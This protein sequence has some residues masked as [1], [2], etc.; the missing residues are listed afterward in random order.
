MIGKLKGVNGSVSRELYRGPDVDVWA[1]VEGALET[2]RKALGVLGGL[3]RRN[4][5][6]PRSRAKVLE[7]FPEGPPDV[8]PP[9]PSADPGASAESLDESPTELP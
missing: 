6:T 4:S 5:F 1:A 2:T 9:R 8:P 7:L 3:I